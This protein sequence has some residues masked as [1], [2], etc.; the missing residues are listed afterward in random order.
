MICQPC[1]LRLFELGDDIRAG[2]IPADD[3]LIPEFGAAVDTDV[4]RP[5][6]LASKI[7]NGGLHCVFS[8]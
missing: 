2:T 6:C 3:E 1:A 4:A 8:F 5:H 7:V